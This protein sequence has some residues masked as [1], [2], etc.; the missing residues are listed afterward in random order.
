M[1]MTDGMME[2]TVAS[3]CACM[4]AHALTAP[5]LIAWQFIEPPLKARAALAA[6]RCI[7]A[8]TGRGTT[9]WSLDASRIRS[10][11]HI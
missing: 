10:L 11:N 4:C 8:G 2:M 9:G 6:N 7:L 1:Y 3:L 5:C